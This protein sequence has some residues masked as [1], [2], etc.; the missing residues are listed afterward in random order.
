MERHQFYA[1]TTYRWQKRKRSTIIWQQ[2]R[3][4]WRITF[5]EIKHDA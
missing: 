5:H 2:G 4:D 3:S 1:E